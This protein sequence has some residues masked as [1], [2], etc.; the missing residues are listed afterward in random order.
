MSQ[1]Q[2]LFTLSAL[3]L[4]PWI[5]SGCG[6]GGGVTQPSSTPQ[7]TSPAPTAIQGIWVTTLSGTAQ[8]VT[9]TLAA[10]S[11]QISRPPDQASGTISVSGDRIDF[12]GS[13]ACAGAGPYRWSLTGMSLAF[14]AIS[15]D[16]CPGRSEVLAGYTYTK[17]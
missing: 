12:S 10:T 13:T 2:K 6:G 11:Y 17:Q 1:L 4:L 5:M 14:T 9:L 16:A 3:T 8:K 15:T 7:A